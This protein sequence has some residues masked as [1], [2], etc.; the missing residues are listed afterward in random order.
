MLKFTVLIGCV[1]V[2]GCSQM[3]GPPA[4]RAGQP[5]PSAISPAAS[6]YKV[7]FAFSGTKGQFPGAG[8]ANLNGTLYGTTY[9]GGANSSGTVF[10]V[11]T[12]GTEKV[13]HSFK[14]GADGSS[15]G[16]GTL[17]YVSGAFY[18]TTET[19]GTFDL[20]TVFRVSPTGTEKV[21]YSFK[22]DKDGS[23]PFAG[24]TNV[25]GT[26]YGTTDFGGASNDGTVFKITTSGV[27][28]VLHSFKDGADGA[29]PTAGL[30]NVNGMLYGTTAKGG[31]PCALECGTVF[32]ISSAGTERVLYAFKGPP[33]DGE[34]PTGG[35][36]DINGTLYGTTEYGGVGSSGGGTVFKITTAG[37][38]KVLHTFTPG[39][40][41]NPAYANLT[42]MKGS[43]YGVAWQGG[44]GF[45]AVFKITA[46]GTESVLHS[47]AA[48]S[49]GA[50]PYGTLVVVNGKLYGTTQAGGSASGGGTV[51]TVGP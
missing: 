46:N 25:R 24:L 20:G 41:A 13:V 2:A 28:R 48:G 4:F 7:L 38:E 34:T 14:P 49:D 32:K 22:G 10:K 47:F 6:G 17:V 35:L 18:G 3:A 1:A 43:L 37:T 45:G 29:N 50:S 40:A 36:I 39:D 26:L 33:H 8:L 44:V 15:P 16:Y 51:Y 31:K 23:R 21:L 11:T 19:G 42:G 5:G 12:S 27:E 30:T 9:G